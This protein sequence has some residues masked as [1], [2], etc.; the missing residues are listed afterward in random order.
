MVL[1]RPDPLHPRYG[2]AALAFLLVALAGCASGATP[3]AGG[4]A[5]VVVSHSDGR[6][7]MACVSFEGDSISGEELLTRS[8]FEVS[9][10]AANA[11]G[12]LVCSIDGEGCTFPKEPCLCR[13]DQPGSCGYWAYFS[14]NAQGEGWTYSAQG[15]RLRRLHDGDIDAWV[16]LTSTG[17]EAV[18]AALPKDIAFA[19]VCSSP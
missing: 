5:G 10:D 17:P 14:Q 7:E 3:G 6:L 18:T 13:C 2:V 19:D 9:L 12:S 8:G 1:P 11:L 16:W 15:A 4:R